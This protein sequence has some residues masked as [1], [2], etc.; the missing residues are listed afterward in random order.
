MNPNEK[1]E[2]LNA[3]GIND[4]EELYSDIPKDIRIDKLDLPDGMDENSL[5]REVKNTLSLNKSFD[6]FLCFNGCGLYPTYVPPALKFLLQR[7]EFYT[8]YTPYQPEINQG[9]LQALFE[10]QSFIAEL[11]GMD[12]VN[13]SMYDCATAL[14]EASLMSIRIKGLKEV[15]IP[16]ALHWEKKSVLNNYLKG[17]GAKIKEIPYDIHTGRIDINSLLK[18]KSSETCCLYIENPNF[19]GVW[20]EDVEEIKQAIE[21]AILIVGVNPLS[22]GIA[23]S[24]GD[25]GADIVIGEGQILGLPMFLSSSLGIFACKKE[26]MRNIPGRVV[27]L[28]KDMDGKR[29]FCLTLQTREQHIRREKAT[30]NICTNETL[31][32]IGAAIYLSLIGNRITDIA[33][34]IAIKSKKLASEIAKLGS[35]IAP[36]FKGNFFNEFVMNSRISSK[37][38][39]NE[40][41]KRNIQ[42]GIRLKPYFPELGESFLV[43]VNELHT[44]EQIDSFIETLKEVEVEL[45]SS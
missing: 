11:T 28:T 1:K 24:P 13:S 34:N 14:G 19:F 16:K 4:I 6:E 38:L 44:Y 7:S 43:S 33:N 45:L 27:G 15:L 22:L 21:E 18:E 5:E 42:C 23:K 12:V 32:A 35:F 37:T 36:L 17:I 29:A 10:Y 2:L 40:L 9:L 20:E 41:L 31:F 3:I 39:A 8:A 30:S 25:Y 26:Y